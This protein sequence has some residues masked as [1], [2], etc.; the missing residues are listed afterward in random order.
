MWTDG[1]SNLINNTSG[2]G[3]GPG[4]FRQHTHTGMP[5]VHNLYLS[6]LCDFGFIGLFLFLLVIFVL[7]NNY[8]KMLRFQETYLQKMFLCCC[9]GL[10]AIGLHGMVDS[11]YNMSVIWFFLGLSMATFLLAQRELCHLKRSN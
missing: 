9:G 11:M 2:I 7:I 4:G 5:H 6:V 3:L 1:V 10:L 8:F